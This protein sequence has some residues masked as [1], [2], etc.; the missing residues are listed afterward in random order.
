MLLTTTTA[1]CPRATHRKTVKH[2][3]RR[4]LP[5]RPTRS[6]RHLHHSRR[7]P[8]RLR[9]QRRRV[10]RS[11]GLRRRRRRL[12]RHVRQSRRRRRGQRHVDAA[13]PR[14]RDGSDRRSVAI[15]ENGGKLYAADEAVAD[16]P[17]AEAAWRGQV[18]GCGRGWGRRWRQ[19]R[20]GLQTPIYLF[21]PPLF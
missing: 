4:L 17:A 6:D 13:A 3:R 1:R 11:R 8:P 14:G 15:V 7:T 9:L 19:R 5:H 12:R 2:R 10:V 21:Y 16:V 20:R 18:S